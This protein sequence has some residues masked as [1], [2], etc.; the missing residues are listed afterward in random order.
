MLISRIIPC[1]DV[2]DDRIVMGMDV[3]GLRDAGGQ[4]G[5]TGRALS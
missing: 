2:M 3:I 1:L 5:R 4:T